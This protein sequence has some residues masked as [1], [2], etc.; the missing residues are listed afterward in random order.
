[1]GTDIWRHLLPLS[2][3]TIEEKAVATSQGLSSLALLILPT[4]PSSDSL[5]SFELG[6]SSSNDFYLQFLYIPFTSILSK[7]YSLK[8]SLVYACTHMPL[9]VSE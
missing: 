4:I 7:P 5:L 2:V 8:H 9:A 6:L 1:M 3:I